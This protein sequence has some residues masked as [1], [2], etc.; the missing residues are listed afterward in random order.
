MKWY[1][2][3]VLEIEAMQAR[4]I[5]GMR[6]DQGTEAERYGVIL[7]SLTSD[8][9]ALAIDLEDARN[10]GQYL[11]DIERA[12]LVDELPQELFPQSGIDGLDI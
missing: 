4:I 7:H 6:R 9:C 3:S 10:P 1:V 11:T 12:E 2:G 8:D 5:A